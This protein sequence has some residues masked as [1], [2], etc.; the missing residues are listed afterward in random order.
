MHNPLQQ[1]RS[2]AE[3]LAALGRAAEVV[4]LPSG[5][6]TVRLRRTLPLVGDIV[7]VSRGPVWETSVGAKERVADLAALGATV[8]NAEAPDRDV[9]PAAGYRQIMT[10]GHVAEL[11]LTGDTAAQLHPK[12]RAS[13]KR[14]PLSLHIQRFDPVRDGWL[15]AADTKAQKE[16]KFNGL[17]HVV[18]AHFAQLHPESAWLARMGRGSAPVAGMLFLTHGRSATY[19]IG[20]TSPDGRAVA[21]HHHLL[22][23][24][25][26][27]LAR[28][29]CTTLD[30]G[31]VDTENAPGLARFKIGTGALIRPL[32]GTWL[33]LPLCR[34]HLA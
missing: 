30:L 24:A 25:C 19:H 6:T 8:I 7:L 22:M 5:T 13:L 4:T 29:G 15:F 2:F 34:R 9:L 33:R 20:W 32:G 27:H 3:T 17:P 28:L 1:S 18:A 16:K 26:E 14:K 31:Q 23:A 12:W 10:A 11:D 21:A